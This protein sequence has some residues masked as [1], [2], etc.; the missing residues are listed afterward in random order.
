MLIY[1]FY[2]TYYYIVDNYIVL[3]SVKP[4][5]N[6]A[7]ILCPPER[8][9]KSINIDD[10]IKNIYD[11]KCGHIHTISLKKIVCEENALEFAPEI[12]AEFSKN[13]QNMEF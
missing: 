3:L 10:I 13:N 1:Y 4:E 11:C 6:M 7:L 9:P 5:E 8:Q 2:Q 12:I